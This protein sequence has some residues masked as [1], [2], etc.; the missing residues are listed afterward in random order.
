MR[1]T[2][3]HII[4]ILLFLLLAGP[5]SPAVPGLAADATPAAAG[6]SPA[7]LMV[8]LETLYR[9]IQ[10]RLPV[11]SLRAQPGALPAPSADQAEAWL[12]LAGVQCE[13]ARDFLRQTSPD[14]A[15][16]EFFLTQAEQ[17][18][19]T[20]LPTTPATL[21]KHD[22]IIENAYFARNDRSPQPY[23]VYT[24]KGYDERTPLPLIIFLHGWVPGTSR[25]RPY[26]VSDFVLD[27][28][29]EHNAI[30]AIPHGRTNTDFQ[31]AGEVDVLRV[32]A[33]MEKFYKVDPDRIYLLGVS[34]GGAGTWQIAMHYPHLFAGA[35]PINGQGD[36][37]RFWQ[38]NFGYPPRTEL[39]SHIQTMIAMVNPL[40]LAGNLAALYT[41]SQHATSCFLG[42]DHTHDIVNR[43]KTY[44]APH[45]FFEDPSQLGHYIYWEPDC[46][47]RAFRHLLRQTR[48][49]APERVYYTTYNLRYSQAYWLQIEH[50]QNSHEPA[51]I[52]ATREADGNIVLSTR[53][54]AKL[55]LTPPASW[56]VDNK[57]L[58]VVWNGQ[59]HQVAMHDGAGELATAAPP[60][61]R[62]GSERRLRKNRAVCGPVADLFNFPFLLV[63][64][65]AGSAAENEANAK[66]AAEVANDWTLYAEGYPT[67][68]DDH[69]VT[70]EMM[71]QFGLVLF[72]LPE[73]NH[74]TARIAG[75][76]PLRISREL[77]VLPD[78][79]QFENRDL[80]LIMTAPNP[81][82]PERYVLI[83][84]GVHWGEGRSPSHRFDRL[85]DFAVYTAE[86]MPN[87]GINRYL[88]TGFFDQRWRYDVRLTDFPPHE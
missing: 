7:G 81:L 8:R 33:E 72:G 12:A 50:F 88:A 61:A 37:F 75:R 84:N 53:N 71:Q 67:V 22:R 25:T 28:A 36:W 58:R 10:T 15:R 24:P 6:H 64:G 73:T 79:K 48:N 77:I 82:A 44:N 17:L 57:P 11:D 32:K 42:A 66:L 3:G 59:E 68:I 43:L 54:V 83:Y 80:G 9:Q 19:E 38:R 29:D 40:D 45:D 76:I 86:T 52:D 69:Q 4:S 14:T 39:P 16:A 70:P 13:R 18:L 34:M 20:E 63:R 46:W 60:Q 85:P 26:L 87:T 1:T 51:V 65:T 35:A 62:P 23:F 30:L 21:I 5:Q 2:S 41:Y 56:I 74:I 47:R 49:R 55:T 27:L 78:G 31:F